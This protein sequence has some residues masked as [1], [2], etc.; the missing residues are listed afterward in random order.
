MRWCSA[1]CRIAISRRCARRAMPP[2]PGRELRCWMPIA[3]RHR[4]SRAAHREGRDCD[5]TAL[6]AA[7]RRGDGDSAQ[8]RTLS[9]PA[10]G[11]R[12]A[13]PEGIHDAD[14]DARTA[15]ATRR[16]VEADLNRRGLRQMLRRNIVSTPTLSPKALA[17]VTARV[18]RKA[19]RASAGTAEITKDVRRS[20]NQRGAGGELTT[21]AGSFAGGSSQGIARP[22][23]FRRR[24]DLSTFFGG[25]QRS[26]TRLL[27]PTAWKP[28]RRGR[29]SSAGAAPGHSQST[30]YV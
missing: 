3:P 9:E 11:G 4:K 13:A 30:S 29:G 16:S 28:A 26:S 27:A 2:E 20:C 19:P 24:R 18:R 23:P 15:L 25:A 1:W 14:R 6:P 22:G 21:K 10:Q 5:R 8:D 12:L 7:L 17:P